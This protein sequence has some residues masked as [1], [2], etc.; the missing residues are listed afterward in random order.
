MLKDL[1]GHLTK[2]KLFMIN[3]Q[4][5]SVPQLIFNTGLIVTYRA[6]NQRIGETI[7]ARWLS[8]SW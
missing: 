4:R 1:K 6:R 3:T 2:S 8:G 7:I 5:L